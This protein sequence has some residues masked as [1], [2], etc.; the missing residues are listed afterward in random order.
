MYSYRNSPNRLDR[1]Y[2]NPPSATYH[3]CGNNGNTNL[4][5]IASFNYRLSYVA[6]PNRRTVLQN[7]KKS[8]ETREYLFC[9]SPKETATPSAD[10]GELKKW[11][12]Y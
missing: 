10:I 4:P 6:L 3:H 8:H 9:D 2:N 1:V 11:K 12:T 7:T 5:D